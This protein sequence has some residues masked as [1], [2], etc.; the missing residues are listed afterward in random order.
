[1]HVLISA[2]LGTGAIF[3]PR[4]VQLLGG[5]SHRVV[6]MVAPAGYGKTTVLRDWPHDGRP[7]HYVQ[8]SAVRD[9]GAELLFRVRRALDTGAPYVLAV[10]G[11]GA[12]S[13][14]L[15]MSLFLHVHSAPLGSSLLLS[16][17]RPIDWATA[18]DVAPS[19]VRQIG[20]AELTF[21]AEEAAD[22][23]AACG[24]VVD[25][26]QAEELYSRTSGWPIAHYLCGLILRES[27]DPTATVRAIVA[28]DGELARGLT[29]R[30]LAGLPATTRRFL[31]RTSV[32]T[33]LTGP[34]CDWLL[35]ATDSDRRLADL[36]DQNMLVLPVY[37]AQG[38]YRYQ[39][40]FGELLRAELNDRRPEAAAYL[41]VRAGD[42]FAIRGDDVAA[43]WHRQAAHSA[44]RNGVRAD[45]SDE[46]PRLAPDMSLAELQ[47]LAFLPSHLSF[48]E[49]GMR[50]GRSGPAIQNFAIGIYR[51][52]GVVSR[53][54]AVERALVL[55]LVASD[56]LHPPG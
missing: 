25:A 24:A 48:D 33:A 42:W 39:R 14:Q 12:P 36:A 2:G 43:R 4:V 55:G 52:L 30:W 40:L 53:R 45:I 19:A 41:H 50:V 47:V 11:I 34:L 15:L 49:I 56:E 27:H 20:P 17:R 23:L 10:D 6:S 22:V 13:T 5:A 28:D 9:D 3:R 51:K 31:T 26:D 29:S 18:L 8:P 44:A 46:L 7:F 1:M 21:T 37:G 35:E 54:D 32:L 38:S 16:G